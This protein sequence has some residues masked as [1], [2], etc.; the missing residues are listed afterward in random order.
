M[1]TGYFSAT[2][3]ANSA[4][5]T[6]P[7]TMS[8]TAVPERELGAAGGDLD[9]AVAAG[10]GEAVQRGVDRLRRR[11]VDRRIGERARLGAVEHLGV[12]LWV[13]M[14][15]AGSLGWELC[16]NV[17]TVSRKRDSLSPPPAPNPPKSTHHTSRSR[18]S[19]PNSPLPSGATY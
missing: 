6:A 3:W 13:A 11:A 2:T 19:P 1:L 14:G 8:L 5:A 4:S 18:E 15:M 17:M 7:M 12:D 10:L 9:D 16:G